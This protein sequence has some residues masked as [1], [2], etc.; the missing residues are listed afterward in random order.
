MR[1]HSVHVAEIVVIFKGYAEIYVNMHFHTA[2]YISYI[3][4]MYASDYTYKA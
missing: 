2:K 1:L 3:H 4:I